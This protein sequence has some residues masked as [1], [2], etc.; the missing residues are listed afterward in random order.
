MSVVRTLL[1]K[2]RRERNYVHLEW[3][4]L[5]RVNQPGFVREKCCLTHLT[6]LFVKANMKTNEGRV[7]N[8]CLNFSKVFDK[9]M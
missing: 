7:V 5:I 2:I 9:V 6:E 8:I 1:E 4:A 3:Q